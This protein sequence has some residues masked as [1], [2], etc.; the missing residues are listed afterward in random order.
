MAAAAI[1][2]AGVTQDMV[3]MTRT[4][5]AEDTGAIGVAMEGEEATDIAEVTAVGAGAALASGSDSITRRYLF[6]IRRFGEP[7]ARL[8]TMPMTTTISG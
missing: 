2:Q 6:T 8:I 4:V 7:T 5:V 1:S 3:D